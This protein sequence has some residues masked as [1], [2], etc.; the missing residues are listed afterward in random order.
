MAL[1]NKVST[2]ALINA[3]VSEV[4]DALINPAKIKEYL[5]GVDAVSDWKPGSPI[6]FRG[7]W[8]NE[9]FEDK[10]LINVMD[11]NKCFGYSYWS[12]FFGTED[13]PENYLD[14]TFSLKNPANKGDAKRRFRRVLCGENSEAPEAS[15][16]P[17]SRTTLALT[18]GNIRTEEMLAKQQDGCEIFLKNIKAVVENHASQK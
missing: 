5:Y 10:A 3:E 6:L 12:P 7:K 13:K 16:L 18:C 9:I 14:Y 4:W 11:T 8:E 1:E 15:P 17:G 2:V